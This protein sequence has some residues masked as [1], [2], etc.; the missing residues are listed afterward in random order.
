MGTSV[1]RRYDTPIRGTL[2]AAA[3]YWVPPLFLLVPPL[4]LMLGGALLADVLLLWT[5]GSVRASR[6]VAD[7]LRTAMS[8]VYMQR[9]IFYFRSTACI[10]SHEGGPLKPTARSRPRKR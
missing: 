10:F 6:D 3:S 1:T 9:A 5:R 4:A 8:K 2:L 7:R